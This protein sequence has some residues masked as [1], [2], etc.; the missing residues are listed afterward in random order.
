MPRIDSRR[1]VAGARNKPG[2]GVSGQG[3][4]LDLHEPE[5]WPEPVEGARCSTELAAAVRRYV[6]L[7]EAEAAAVA[8]WV[9]A[10]HAFDAFAIFPRLFINSPEKGCGKSTL[11]DVLSRLVPKPL[12]ASGITR[13]RC[14][15]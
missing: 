14:S 13:R 3:R 1:L 2:D 5:P 8:L 6:V 11:L 12:G 10:V 4:P 7:G 15:A 9:V